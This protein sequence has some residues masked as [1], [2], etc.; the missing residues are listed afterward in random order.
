MEKNNIDNIKTRGWI[1]PLV[2]KL[3]TK[4]SSLSEFV[5]GKRLD[6]QK[7]SA[8]R[9]IT[10][11]RAKHVDT[12]VVS[13]FII[14]TLSYFIINLCVGRTAWHLLLIIA[15]TIRIVEIV[16]SIIRIVLFDRSNIKKDEEPIVAAYSRMIIL[17]ILNYIDVVI[18]F[19]CI[20]SLGKNLLHSNENMDWFTSI[21]FSAI[22]QMTIGYG[23]VYPIGYLRYIA[24]TQGFIGL[25]IIVFVVGRF[26]S[27]L[28]PEKSIDDIKFSSSEHASAT[29]KDTVNPTSNDKV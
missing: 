25:I 3:V 11:E 23:D 4:A 10:A 5:L 27:L 1:T 14:N 18:C 19:A 2:E 29:G 16:S 21:Y 15:P 9:A 20:Y 26:I 6:Y 8:D 12:Y 22:T 24:C 13:F 17:G 28:A 7:K